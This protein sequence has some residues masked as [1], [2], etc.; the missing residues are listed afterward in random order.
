[1]LYQEFKTQ[2]KLVILNF[3]SFGKKSLRTKI[4]TDEKAE[5]SDDHA[6][7]SKLEMEEALNTT[8]HRSKSSDASTEEENSKALTKRHKTSKK[9][10][11][12][13]HKTIQAST[14]E[15]I[16]ITREEVITT[17]LPKK[18]K[19][20]SKIQSSSKSENFFSD[21]STENQNV[22]SKEDE[23][24]ATTKITRKPTK[25]KISLMK[26]K[27]V[28]RSIEGET[29][30]S[31]EEDLQTTIKIT[32]KDEKPHKKTKSTPKHTKTVEKSI[33]KINESTEK[34]FKKEK[35][36]NREKSS[37][38]HTY[39][40]RDNSTEKPLD[41]EHLKSIENE[42]ETQSKKLIN[43]ENFSEK[44]KSFPKNVK[45]RTYVKPKADIFISIENKKHPSKSSTKTVKAFKNEE[46][47]KRFPTS[48][49]A[50]KKAK[51]KGRN[52]SNAERYKTLS[53]FDD[54][55]HKKLEK[56]VNTKVSIS[57]T[58]TP[59][60]V[61][62]ST[63]ATSTVETSSSTPELYETPVT[64][65]KT[66]SISTD[67]NMRASQENKSS[68][69]SNEK[70]SLKLEDKTTQQQTT[71][72]RISRSYLQLIDF[73]E[74]GTT[75]KLNLDAIKTTINEELKPKH[76]KYTLSDFWKRHSNK[77]EMKTKDLTDTT[78]KLTMTT[79]NNIAMVT[80]PT[81]PGYDEEK[82]PL[83]KKKR[84]K[85]KRTTTIAPIAPIPTAVY[86]RS[87][88]IEHLNNSKPDKET[89][90]NRKP[91]DNKLIADKENATNPTT[92]DNKIDFY[93]DNNTDYDKA[94]GVGEELKD[95]L[96]LHDI[97]LDNKNYTEINL[98]TVNALIGPE[99]NFP[100]NVKRKIEA[101][102]KDG[103]AR[104]NLDRDIMK[105]YGTPISD[106]ALSTPINSLYTDPLDNLN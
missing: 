85:R 34:L 74:N 32:K 92:L 25:T 24:Q 81:T 94:T 98:D 89:T 78:T 6:T 56:V 103:T 50:S 105:L 28:E 90:T 53:E 66:G 71:T 23:I 38:R 20:S 91:L 80:T 100:E 101:G 43:K 65:S 61:E 42:E 76:F 67:L 72:K 29:H 31:S 4:K 106:I 46:T 63:D 93:N 44:R 12:K 17:K 62:K 10:K 77:V 3:F 1:M 84:K 11:N 9:S 79:E 58:P 39:K 47:T 97:K 35:H 102:L 16:Y 45:R 40:K 88:A 86:R 73:I 75:V 104:R 95:F 19:K 64:A 7:S 8:D 30:E 59:Q 55:S 21:K 99:V 48:P 36:K 13:Q 96:D 57:R 82:N 54:D 83:R 52:S 70:S 27:S 60:M 22:F 33:E 14:E 41:E 37:K 5:E 49:P 18:V 51:F 87:N 69:V 68:N 15:E 2:L 26:Q